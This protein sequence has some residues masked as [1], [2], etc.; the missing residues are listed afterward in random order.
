MQAAPIVMMSAI[1]N[2]LFMKQPLSGRINGQTFRARG[3]RR[4]VRVTR[5]KSSGLVTALDLEGMKSRDD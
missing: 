4:P 5:I 1:R 3:E 2:T